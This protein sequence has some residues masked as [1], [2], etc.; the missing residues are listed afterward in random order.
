[1]N[2]RLEKY[3][4]RLNS[5]VGR[6]LPG[7]V[8]YAA[9]LA[10]PAGT[11]E[12]LTGAVADV[13]ASDN[14]YKQAKDDRK[15]RRQAMHV[16]L[17]A[18]VMFCTLARD[19]MKPFLGTKHSQAW[20]IIGFNR[21]LQ[22]PRTV[23]GILLLLGAIGSYLE[24]HP[25]RENAGVDVTALRA[26]TLVTDLTAERTAVAEY[27]ANVDRAVRTRRQKATVARRRL[28]SLLDDLEIALDPLDER[29]VEFGFNKP[30]AK[31]VPPAPGNITRV[32]NA[33]NTVALKWSRAARAEHYR[34]WRK[35][36]GVDQELVAIG[37]PTDTNFTVEG[38]PANSTVEIAI[39]AVNNGGEGVLSEL[40]TV[41]TH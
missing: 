3:P 40:I 6:A 13:V 14:S 16:A 27:E 10:L 19:M 32:L 30:G 39:S 20:Q 4:D 35:I 22:I 25:E 21:S 26:N 33:N 24:D 5:Q 1:M 31:A 18:S 36:N 17:Q 12:G 38:L 8:K 11:A 15:T 28:R 37:S 2:N 41:V 29:W 9:A 7:V 34:V 23:D